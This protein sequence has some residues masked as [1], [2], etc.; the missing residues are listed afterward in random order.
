VK[1][2]VEFIFCRHALLSTQN[3]ARIV[4]EKCSRFYDSNFS[5]FRKVKP[6]T[7]AV[8]F[9]NVTLFLRQKHFLDSVNVNIIA[10]TRSDNECILHYKIQIQYKIHVNPKAAEMPAKKSVS[11][12][13]ISLLC[14]SKNLEYRYVVKILM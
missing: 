3:F 4:Q 6:L 13:V 5:L 7:I 14:N 2:F 8:S 1:A 12:F 10:E 11:V 9:N